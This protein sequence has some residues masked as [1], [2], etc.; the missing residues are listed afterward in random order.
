MKQFIAKEEGVDLN[1][2]ADIDEACGG[3]GHFVYGRPFYIKGSSDTF[4][5]FFFGSSE[6]RQ[7]CWSEIARKQSGLKRGD[8]G[9]QVHILCM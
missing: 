3:E 8:L 6:I 7:Y 1:A 9:V 5:F 2:C 4:P